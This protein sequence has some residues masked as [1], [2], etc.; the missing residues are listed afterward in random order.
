MILRAVESI[1]PLRTDQS[2]LL[3]PFTLNQLWASHILETRSYALLCRQLGPEGC[4]IHHSMRGPHREDVPT[5]LQHT[6]DEYL[7]VF[8]SAPPAVV[9]ATNAATTPSVAPSE[10]ETRLPNPRSGNALSIPCPAYLQAPRMPAATAA[11]PAY[12]LPG[13]RIK[14][15]VKTYT[16]HVSAYLV[17]LDWT[18][19]YLKAMI[20]TRLKIPFDRQRL[21]FV[22]EAL[23]DDGLLGDYL[24]QTNT[25]LDLIL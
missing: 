13:S 14:I 24:L 3:A 16:N 17:S 15:Y 23:D 25:V 4:I 1:G 9:W 19:T 5:K 2:S 12:G 18:V 8:R 22:G 7:A 6:L 20:H 21:V 10:S 11:N